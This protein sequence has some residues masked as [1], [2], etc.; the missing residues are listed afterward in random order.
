[1]FSRK[2]PDL[3]C[4]STLCT[5]ASSARVQKRSHADA[6]SEPSSTLE[7]SEECQS[8][9]IR[10]RISA[11][12]GLRR[13]N[14]ERQGS[15]SSSSSSSSSS[16]FRSVSEASALIPTDDPADPESVTSSSETATEEDSAD[17]LASDASS[18]DASSESPSDS[19][20]HSES[21]G[22]TEVAEQKSDAG[23]TSLPV[24]LKPAMDSAEEAADKAKLLRLRL[25]AFLPQLAAANEE[26]E[27]DRA[28]GR[29]AEK[30]LDVLRE[31]EETYIEMVGL[32]S[33]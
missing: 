23:L 16:S 32:P 33:C 28:E 17:D 20:S 7:H 29:L 6:L 13:Q 18:G 22:G 30:Q 5:M 9:L 31:G 3:P 11:E 25:T 21:E 4:L 26:L 1:M 10:R 19:N 27:V 2:I 24:M 8:R 15:V 14:P 12:S